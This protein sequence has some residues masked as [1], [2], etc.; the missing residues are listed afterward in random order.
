MAYG[1]EETKGDYS[2]AVVTADM[3]IASPQSLRSFQQLREQLRARHSRPVSDQSSRYPHLYSASIDPRHSSVGPVGMD[4]GN[5]PAG[6]PVG[7]NR[8]PVRESPH[9]PLRQTTSRT[10]ESTLLDQDRTRSPSRVLR[11]AEAKQTR[12]VMRPEPLADTVAE[13]AQVMEA[14]TVESED[15][16]RGEVEEQSD[17]GEEGVSDEEEDVEELEAVEGPA[18]AAAPAP[19]PTATSTTTASTAPTAASAP[20]SPAPAP[21]PAPTPVPASMSPPPSASAQQSQ[22]QEPART[23]AVEEP[24]RT[25]PSAAQPSLQPTTTVTPTA[26]PAEI[27][28][29]AALSE[30][31]LKLQAWER[32][33]RERERQLQ[34]YKDSLSRPLGA[35]KAPRPAQP[36]VPAPVPAQVLR[37]SEESR[38][39]S[40]T[41]FDSLRVSQESACSLPGHRFETSSYRPPD[42][43]IHNHI[44][45]PD[46]GTSHTLPFAAPSTAPPAPAG[47]DGRARF[48]YDRVVDY[49]SAEP[50]VAPEPLPSFPYE[51]T[52]HPPRSGATQPATSAPTRPMYTVDPASMSRTSVPEPARPSFADRHELHGRLYDNYPT[53]RESTSSRSPPQVAGRPPPPTGRSAAAAAARPD[54]E[55]DLSGL[56]LAVSSIFAI[57]TSV[58]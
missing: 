29:P 38:Q 6:A 1:Y 8:P 7:H 46:T 18:A 54:E 11:G 19:A 4:M 52:A 43:H 51:Y 30:Q 57:H 10:A 15:D 25:N 44:S 20:A 37:S 2:P 40:D 32:E 21:S 12:P 23:S 26:A 14:E 27:F 53:Y 33:L 34:E 16:D 47:L 22:W 3:N 17:G 5:K 55:V 41:P 42:I 24:S 28:D 45:A 36:P 13:G 39:H 56:S 35:H 50:P 48:P 58:D 9:S 31:V 49:D